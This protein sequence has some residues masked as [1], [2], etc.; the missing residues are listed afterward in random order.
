MTDFTAYHGVSGA[1]HQQHVDQ[2]SAQGYRPVSISVSGDPLD[3][4]YAAVFEQGVTD[5]WFARHGLR[6]DP[7]IDPDTL[8]HE[9]Q[10]AFDSGFIPRCLAVYGASSDPR[11]AG[12]WVKNTAPTPWS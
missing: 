4:R 7:V 3:P 8:T 12:I 11:F 9:N 10:R 1:S 2:L 5:L 6:W